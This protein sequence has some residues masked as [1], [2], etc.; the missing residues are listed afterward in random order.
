MFLN[1]SW[2]QTS[3]H[4]LSQVVIFLD[5][6][7][8]KQ[9]VEAAY[10]AYRKH[11]ATDTFTLQFMAFITINYLNCCYHQDADK[12]YAESTFKFLQELPVDPAIGLEKLIGKFYQAVFSGDE[13][14]ARS[15]KSI[16]QDCGYASIIDDI[17][18]D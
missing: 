10:A 3:Y 7:D 15:L 17:E 18:I 13:Q 12:S 2:D 1:E 9:F 14:K 11:P 5:V 6:N 8:S 4:F 16:I